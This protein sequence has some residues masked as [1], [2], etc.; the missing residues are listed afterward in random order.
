[1]P[2][3]ARIMTACAICSTPVTVK[4]SRLTAAKELT[5]SAACIAALRQ[6]NMLRFRDSG[7]TRHAT[8]PVCGQ[9]FTRRPSQIAKYKSSYCSRA[10]RAIGI[11]GPNPGLITGWHETCRMCGTIVWRTPATI[12]PNTYCSLQCSGRAP[13]RRVRVERIAKPCEGCGTLL[14]L[15]PVVARRQ[16]FCSVRCTR[17]T[18]NQTRKGIATGPWPPAQRAKLSVTLQSKYSHEWAARRLQLSERMRGEGNPRYR[19]GRALR[20]YAPGFTVRVKLQ[21]AKRDRFLCRRCGV[22]QSK[23]TH[24]VHHIDGEKHDHSLENLVLLCKPCHGKTHAEMDRARLLAP[25]TR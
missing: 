4:P 7:E 17:Y 3:P 18:L 14:R 5:C 11:R 13:R 10:C 1:M 12:Q 24:V 6:R 19:D 15:R 25:R 8:C 20:P 22:P 9:S 21:V 16:R 2:R 23:G